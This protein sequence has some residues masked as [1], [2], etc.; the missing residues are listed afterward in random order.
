VREVERSLDSA[1]PDRVEEELDALGLLDHC[2][3][4][5]GRRGESP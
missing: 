5:L 1:T 3:S 4:A 2:R